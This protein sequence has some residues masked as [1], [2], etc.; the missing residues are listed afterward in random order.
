MFCP[1]REQA[2]HLNQQDEASDEI[3]KRTASQIRR[4]SEPRRDHETA[5]L[6][7]SQ[8]SS[9]GEDGQALD[10]AQRALQEVRSTFLPLPPP[11]SFQEAPTRQQQVYSG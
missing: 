8:Q 3:R 1:R 7:R 2:Q 5:L 9:E 6:G 4:N 10:E 11:R